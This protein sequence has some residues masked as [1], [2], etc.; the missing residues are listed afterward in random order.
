MFIPFSLVPHYAQIRQ[1]GLDAQ[2]TIESWLIKLEAIRREGAI[3]RLPPPVLGE[4]EDYAAFVT[5]V[6]YTFSGVF[7]S[8][9][10]ISL[11]GEWSYDERGERSPNRYQ[12]DVFLAARYALNDVENTEL[13]VS[14]VADMDYSTRLLGFEAKRDLSDSWTATVEAA[15][16]LEVDE[17]DV[18]H[19]TRRDGYVLLNVTYSF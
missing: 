7:D 15:V 3:N 1:Y 17:K 11:L 19:E 6:E 2:L 13:I 14:A 18:I 16:M 4:K 5:G 10:D 12:N 8:D 9:A